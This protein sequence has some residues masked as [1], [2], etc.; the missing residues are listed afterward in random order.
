MNRNHLSTSLPSISPS[1]KLEIQLNKQDIKSSKFQKNIFI[2]RKDLDLINLLAKRGIN[3]QIKVL[4]PSNKL[5]QKSKSVNIPHR[6]I[7]N[8]TSSKHRHKYK[9]IHSDLH[10]ISN[11]IQGNI[12]QK[13]QIE[14]IQRY[15]R[16]RCKDLFRN[17][18][19]RKHIFPKEKSIM[20]SFIEFKPLKQ[21]EEIID[22]ND[23]NNINMDNLNNI[24][25]HP[26]F[27]KIYCYSFKKKHSRNNNN[28]NNNTTTIS[29][30]ALLHKN[31]SLPNISNSKIQ[32]NIKQIDA[33]DS[34]SYIAYPKDNNNIIIT[35]HNKHINKYI[36]ST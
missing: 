30:S 1:I 10:Y 34:N 12:K 2:K 6:L 15:E 5:K 21:K 20:K 29:N 11:I 4:F 17:E 28:D 36:K 8:N 16:E 14:I 32:S 31:Y 25:H 23:N 7:N 9:F 13:D 3:K 35:K 33:H 19:L 27:D 24:N 18:S 26:I 22:I